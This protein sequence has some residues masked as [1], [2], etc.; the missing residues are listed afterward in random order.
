MKERP[1][2]GK[3][4]QGIGH[5]RHF[6]THPKWTRLGVARAILSHCERGA[7][8]AGI[9]ELECH[10]SLNAEAFYTAMGFESIGPLDMPMAEGV[11]LPSVHMRRRI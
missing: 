5:I 4:K 11:N 8:E 3:V 6:G 7:R 9:T 2:D 1:G 10:S